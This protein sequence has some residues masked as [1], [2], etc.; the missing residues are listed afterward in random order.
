ML[1]GSEGDERDGSTEAVC[2]GSAGASSGCVIVIIGFGC[3]DI[4]VIRSPCGSA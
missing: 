3:G 4:V 1:A 2:Y